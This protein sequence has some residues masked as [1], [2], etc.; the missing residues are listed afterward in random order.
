[1]VAEC[2]YETERD[3]DGGVGDD[4]GDSSDGGEGRLFSV[5]RRGD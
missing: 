5:N 3:L 2:D 1:M 4:G